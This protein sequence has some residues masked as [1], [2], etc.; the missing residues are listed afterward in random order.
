ML[1]QFHL[2]TLLVSACVFRLKI[3][4]LQF[5][6]AVSQTF[7][8]T[9]IRMRPAPYLIMTVFCPPPYES[10]LLRPEHT[11]TIFTARTCRPIKMQRTIIQL[12]IV[13]SFQVYQLRPPLSVSME[14]RRFFIRLCKYS[15][16]CSF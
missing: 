11:K 2:E 8:K 14:V 6:P 15:N 7:H 12:I 1:P 3:I 16:G 4:I 5:L 10:F 9:L 13:F